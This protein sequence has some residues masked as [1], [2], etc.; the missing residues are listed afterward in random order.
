MILIKLSAYFLYRQ[1]EYQV[2]KCPIKERLGV[3]S[4]MP[5]KERKELE[6]IEI[7][8][9]VVSRE[10]SINMKSKKELLSYW[11]VLSIHIPAK[12]KKTLLRA[13]I[14]YG[15]ERDM[16]LECIIIEKNLPILPIQPV[17]IGQALAKANKMTVD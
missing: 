7:K 3:R 6:K 16:I 8:N 9:E 15:A 5:E 2:I 10:L 12:V 11:S 4:R 14:D 17:Y 13:L 1:Q